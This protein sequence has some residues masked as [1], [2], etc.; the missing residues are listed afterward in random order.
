MKKYL[1]QTAIIT[2]ILFQSAG[3]AHAQEA[4]SGDERIDL[5]ER[6]LHERDKLLIELLDR[7][8]ALEIR[9]GVQNTS[10]LA[11]QR[12][13]PEVLESPK[14]GS[15]APGSVVVDA[16]MAERALERSLSREGALLLPSG[17]LE[18]EPGFFLARQENSTATF[19]ENDNGLS[20]GQNN[21]NINQFAVDLGIR[22]GLPAGA[23]FEVGMPFRLATFQNVTE[24]GFSP[25]RTNTNSAKGIGDLR[26][27][28]AKTLLREG[29]GHP[30]LI[31]RVTWDSR[32]GDT[33]GNG[34]NLG[35]GF[36]EIRGSLTAIKRQDPVVFIGGISYQYSF[37][38]GDVKPGS[39]YGINL[40]AAYALSPETSLRFALAGS[41][42][43]RTQ[44]L[45]IP[46]NGSDRLRGSFI[47]GGSTL[48]KPGV[49]M[50]M[51]LGIGLTKDADDVFLSVSFPIRFRSPL[52]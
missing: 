39:L 43:E 21:L 24:S 8:E 5:L 1:L 23:Q 19:I 2:V 7:I 40:G 20:I 27:G 16:S 36:D 49:L 42:Q 34:I 18:M 47:F 14:A 11:T 32:I 30:D 6:Q 29:P 3:V 46:I 50:N 22:L 31:G 25:I 12:Q 48:L 33:A 4:Q 28:L 45:A 13:A 44:R 10:R 38:Y 41:W 26:L 35:S 17:R 37:R 52:F 51:S 15:T 9:L